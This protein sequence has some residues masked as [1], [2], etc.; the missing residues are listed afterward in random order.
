L[1]TNL[2]TWSAAFFRSGVVRPPPYSGV[3]AIVVL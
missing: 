2:P 1:P 3:S